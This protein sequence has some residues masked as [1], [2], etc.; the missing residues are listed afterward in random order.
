MNESTTKNLSVKSASTW[1]KWH[2]KR[3]SVKK[4]CGVMEITRSTGRDAYGVDE[5][6]AG[7]SMC[8]G[9]ANRSAFF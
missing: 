2:A 1:K 5:S 3:G 9:N 6:D 7:T 4:E 8:R